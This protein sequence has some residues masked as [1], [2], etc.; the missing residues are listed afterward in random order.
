NDRW[1]FNVGLRYDKNDA[2]DSGGNTAADDSAFSPRLAVNWD[3]TGNGKLRLSASYAKYV[4][5]IQEGVAGSG[6]TLAGVPASYYYYW[7]GDPINANAT[8]P[9]IPTAQ[10][11][12][13][14]YSAYGVSQLNQF[15]N[16]P[17]DYA[18][19]PG[20]NIIIVDPLKSPSTN[21][22]VLGV[23]GTLFNN[24]VYR[25]DL[26]R[27]EGQ[28]YYSIRRDMSTGQVTGQFGDEYDL[29]IHENTDKAERE[30][31]GLHTSFAWRTGGLNLAANWTWSHLIG[32][33][34][35]EA[36]G[37]GPGSAA[38]DQYPE[39]FD[40]AWNAPSGDLQGDQ[41]HR[42]R[43]VGTYDFRLGSLGIT[44]GLIQSFD[45]GLPYQAAGGVAT[46]PYVTNPGYVAPPTTVTYFFTP[47]GGYRTDDI[48]STDLSLNLSLNLGP[49]E[50]FVLPQI[51]NVFNNDG[52]RAVN[53]SVSV[54]TGA[55]PSATTGLVQ[56]NPFTTAPKEC[57]QTATAGE[58]SAMGANWKKG[59]N[60]GNP[61]SAASYQPARS[62]YV[63]M[64]IRF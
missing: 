34:V 57:P 20:L 56:F 52:V 24:F 27:R 64:G 10:V 2:V 30:Y 25:L 61:T 16:V 42:V 4:G 55:T 45:S 60:F 58:C 48:W 53:S 31:T 11:L 38:F 7:T 5:Q 44:P 29:G 46:R 8:G 15:P 13:Q 51:L 3:V 23:G 12:A 59:V 39:Y 26:V 32:N 63:S 54:G 14:M 28:D 22:Y 33:F 37:S 49:V 50:I 40:P 47:R 6:A 9:W 36:S 21:E 1:S 19:V 43:I 18:N 17:P 35:G 62:Y 41:R